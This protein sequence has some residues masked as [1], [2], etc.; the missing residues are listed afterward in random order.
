MDVSPAAD[1]ISL[2]PDK[3]ITAFVMPESSS[4]ASQAS[5]TA[6]EKPLSLR[7]TSA[8]YGRADRSSAAIAAAVVDRPLAGR[9][10]AVTYP[11]LTVTPYQL[12]ISRSVF[13]PVL[14]VQSS[15]EVAS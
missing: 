1:G 9:A 8:R 3:S 12:P 6:S 15:P 14:S 10:R 11:P 7:S 13:Q 5:T 2:F 4:V